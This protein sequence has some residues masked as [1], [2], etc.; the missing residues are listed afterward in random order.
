MR[1]RNCVCTSLKGGFL[2]HLLD[3]IGNLRRGAAGILRLE[4]EAVPLRRVVA[5]GDDDGAAGVP[6]HHVVRDHRSRRSAVA[7]KRRHSAA[8]RRLRDGPRKIFRCKARVVA[9]H[10]APAGKP[11]LTHVPYH[12]LRAKPNV[13]E[14]KVLG[15]DGSPSV[16]A[17]LDCHALIPLPDRS[18]TGRTRPPAVW[19]RRA[20]APC[21]GPGDYPC[22]LPRRRR[23]CSLRPR[24][25]PRPRSHRRR[26]CTLLVQPHVPR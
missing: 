22:R 19:R 18:L 1:P 24:L 14:S 5:C 21:R 26:Q 6:V 13:L 9:D 15:D 17:E 4:L 25:P 11:L 2:Y 3:G 16:R 7:E 10:Q 20:T 8:G 12:S 23:L